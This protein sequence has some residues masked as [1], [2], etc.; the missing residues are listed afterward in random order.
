MAARLPGAEPPSGTTAGGRR[1]SAGHVT[2]GATS[3]A[4]ADACEGSRRASREGR[5]MS[6][7]ADTTTTTITRTEVASA[8][9]RVPLIT[10]SF[11]VIKGLSTALGESTSDW[12]VHAMPPALAV[13]IGFSCFV[14][15][16]VV[17]F[18]VRALRGVGVLAH[19]RHG[20]H[21]R[22]DGGRRAARRPPCAI[23]R[24]GPALR[25]RPD[26]CLRHLA[27]RRRHVVGPRDLHTA[28]RGVLLG[29][30]CHDLRPRH[31]R[32]RSDRDQAEP[33]VPD[34][35]DPL[36]RRDRR[37]RPSPTGAGTSVARWPSG[38]PLS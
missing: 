19:R 20:R 14:A 3:T 28:P 1:E 4:A 35:S 37:R 31:R 38:P 10:A 11:W 5:Q 9:L 21:L 18:S 2:A 24:L 32:R 23:R 6:N 26:R 12:A 27:S 25:G 30:C 15:S 34:L 13:L 33:R 22:H 29:S 7:A 17:Q 8:A 16:L 36:R